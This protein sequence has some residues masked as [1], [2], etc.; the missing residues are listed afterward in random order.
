MMPQFR[1]AKSQRQL[2]EEEV[3]AVPARVQLPLSV[4]EQLRQTLR[5]LLQALAKSIHEEGAN[6][7]LG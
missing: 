7:S 2:F 3:P 4:Q 5:Q 1:R 6:E